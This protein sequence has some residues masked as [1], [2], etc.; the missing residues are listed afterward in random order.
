MLK[1]HGSAVYVAYYDSS[2]LDPPEAFL[3]WLAGAF[4]GA[5]TTVGSPNPQQKRGSDC[6]LFVLMG[7][8]FISM[9][10]L[11]VTQAESDRLL[12]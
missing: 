3:Q 2:G 1:Q 5:S 10:R 12:P 9:R 8:S 7:A 6:G 4:P 11:H